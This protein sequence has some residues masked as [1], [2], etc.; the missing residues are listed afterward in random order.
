MTHAARKPVHPPN[1]TARTKLEALKE[2]CDRA[3]SS[4]ASE[5]EPWA[6]A[7]NAL[8]AVRFDEAATAA[9]ARAGI[10][11]DDLDSHRFV[12]I[13]A[14]LA[15]SI[16]SKPPDLPR[17]RFHRRRYGKGTCYCWAEVEAPDGTLLFLGDPWPGNKWPAAILLPTAR[18][19]LARH[20]GNEEEA[21][22]ASAEAAAAQVRHSARQNRQPTA[23]G[24]QDTKA[25]E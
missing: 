12:E 19:A 13:A 10:T 21:A 3:L 24:L 4:P 1:D 23:G 20:M 5:D 16:P 17:I 22:A 8:D 6:E 9:A 18:A 15:R 11:S 25:A 14:S 7:E 2:A